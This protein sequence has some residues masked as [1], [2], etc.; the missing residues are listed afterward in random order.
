MNP[1]M[2]ASQ[3][4]KGHRYERTVAARLRAAGFPDARTTR[5]ADPLLDPDGVD[6]TGTHPFRVQCKAVEKLGSHH[7]T[8]A[9]IATKA[10]EIPALFH[11]RSRQGEVVTLRAE[12][13]E[14]I[15]RWLIREKI[16]NADGE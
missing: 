8:L 11:K 3:R 10:G 7:R 16:I 9:G 14:E 1:T 13:F 4:R 2:S 12:D 6:I 15:L 5:A